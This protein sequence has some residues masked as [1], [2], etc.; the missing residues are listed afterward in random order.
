MKSGEV[1][2]KVKEKFPVFRKLAISR[3]NCFLLKKGND[4]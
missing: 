4:M 2:K 1:R 3:K